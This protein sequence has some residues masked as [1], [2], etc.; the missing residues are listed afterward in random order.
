MVHSISAALTVG[1]LALVV[2]AQTFWPAGVTAI[3][4]VEFWL[5]A[6]VAIDADL[7][8]AL[9]EGDLAGF[10]AAMQRLG[11]MQAGKT[12]RP[13]EDRIRGALQLLKLQASM[14]LLQIAALVA[15][16]ILFR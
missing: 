14:L 7:L 3:G 8:A 13:M 12:G 2:F 6:R 4:A 15:G 11:L 10:D 5:A 16:G 9:D 1:S